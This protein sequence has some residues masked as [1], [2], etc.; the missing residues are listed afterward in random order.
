[1]VEMIFPF[2]L[3]L[4]GTLLEMPQWQYFIDNLV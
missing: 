2:L 1:M 3:F 4:S